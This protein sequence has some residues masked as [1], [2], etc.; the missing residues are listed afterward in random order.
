MKVVITDYQYTDIDTERRIITKSGA[1]LYDYQCKTE[2]ELIAATQDADAVIVQYCKMTPKVISNLKHCKVIIKY[3]IGVDNIDLEAATKQGVYV[4]NVPAYGVE[5]VAN[6]TM[7]FL[8]SW[9]RAL[10]VLTNQLR[11]GVWGYGNCNPV[12]R[13]ST[14]TLGLLGFGRI[15]MQV[16]KRANAFNMHVLVYDPFVSEEAIRQNGAV[17]AD[18]DTIFQ[19]S[20]FL[21]VHCPMTEATKHLI[22]KNTLAKMK[23]TA[24][25][26]N[27]ARGGV[28]CEAD[29]AEAL[30][31]GVIAGA[32]VDVYESEPIGADHPLLSLPNVI[33]T[34]HLAWYSEQ[35]IRDVQRMAAEEVVHVLAGN[36]PTSLMNKEL[37]K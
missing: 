34:S 13:L 12:K 8:L 29:L 9:A 3:G 6:H 23:N 28:I 16:A 32:A 37:L 21:S 17:P 19:Q 33:A 35:A 27:T 11:N 20:D 2:E 22:N 30:K 1:Q 24:Y 25:V 18:L 10:P 14:C 15:P 31:S 36:P 5:E 26:I 4:A 7:A